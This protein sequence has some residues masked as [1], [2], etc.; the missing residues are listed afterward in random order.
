MLLA[1]RWGSRA[2]RDGRGNAVGFL[3]AAVGG[4]L[5]AVAGAKGER[6]ESSGEQY[7]LF[8]KY[9]KTVEE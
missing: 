2:G 7:E 1:G 3:G 9:K 4:A 5:L 6:G 8:H